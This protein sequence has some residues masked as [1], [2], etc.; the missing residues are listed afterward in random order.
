MRPVVAAALAALLL[1]TAGCA[2]SEDAAAPGADGT[3]STTAPPA[4]APRAPAARELSTDP[5]RIADDL[6]ADENALRDP[7]SSEDLLTAAAQRQQA[8]YRAIG[9]NPEWDGV[10]RPRI[11]PTLLEGYDRNV[12]ARRQLEALTEARDVVPAWRIV[13]PAPADDLLGYYREAEAATGV[14]WNYLAAINFIETTFGRVAGVSPAGAQG[15]MQ[16][17]P[18]TFARYGDGGDVNAP[19]DAIMA[20][21]RLLAADGFA[22]DPEGALFR[23]NN[24]EHYVRAVDDY[25]TAMAAD[26]TAFGAYH[27]WQVYYATTMGDIPLPVG[28]SEAAETPVAE[29]LGRNTKTSAAV[30]ISPQSEAALTRMLAARNADVAADPAQRSE[31]IS[32]QFLGIPYVADTL[33]GTESI[34]EELVVDL[35]GVDC[36]TFVDYVEALKRAGTRDEFIAALTAVRYRDGIVA[37]SNRKH[38]FTDWAAV[39]PELATDITASLSPAAVQV[40]KNLNA[41]DSGGAYL[42]GLPVVPRAVAYI[43]SGSVDANVVGQLRTGDYVGAYAT[44]GGLDVTHVGV[45]VNGA[46]GPVLRN[47]SSLSSNNRVVDEPFLGYVQTVPGIVVLRP[48]E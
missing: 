7:A 48:V 25:A 11:P 47:A 3:S 1:V 26:P 45:F 2:G 38:F 15:P 44:D 19:R 17:L 24:S 39:A 30:R 41:K 16:F 13:A 29:Y 37:F 20:A 18:A 36:F 42:P 4:P 32:R 35:D 46:D 33:V 34:P 22:A 27:R 31:L 43:P 28:Y 12:D 40:G 10:V 9:E 8:A 23:Y 6:V 21:G 5:A 14:G